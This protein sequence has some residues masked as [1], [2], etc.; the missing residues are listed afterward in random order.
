MVN[1]AGICMEM[2]E[3]SKRPIWE[4][5]ETAFEKTMDVNIKGVF[6]GT[7][8]ASQQMLAQEPG[9]SMDRAWIINLGSVLGLSG[10]PGVCEY[11]SLLSGSDRLSHLVVQSAS[12]YDN[13]GGLATLSEMLLCS[14]DTANP[15]RLGYCSY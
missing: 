15:S 1:N 6:L 2:G 5:E 3:H 13:L 4:Y 10:G 8:Y 11:F 12:P 9:P 14:T 7:K